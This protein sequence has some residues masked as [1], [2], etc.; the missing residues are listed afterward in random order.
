MTGAT[1]KTDKK[2]PFLFFSQQSGLLCILFR[3]KPSKTMPLTMS[4]NDS[5]KNKATLR[6][7]TL[8]QYNTTQGKTRQAKIRQDRTIQRFIFV[9]WCG[10]FILSPLEPRTKIQKP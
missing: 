4:N 7:T 8:P 6:Y 1:E 5:D 2:K 3:D 10:V 9:V